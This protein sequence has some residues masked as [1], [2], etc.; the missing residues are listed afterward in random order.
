MARIARA[1]A[2][3]LVGWAAQFGA[4][5]QSGANPGDASQRAEERVRAVYESRAASLDRLWARVVFEL[6]FR[7]AEGVARSEQGEG[8]LQFREPGRLALTLGK[9]GQRVLYLGCDPDRFWFIDMTDGGRAHVGRNANVGKPCMEE[10][11]LPA[12][13]AD[14][15][16]MLGVSRLPEGA[17]GRVGGGAGEARILATTPT[18]RLRITAAVETGEPSRIELLPSAADEGS[19]WV[20]VPT[21]VAS[22]SEYTSVDL[23]AGGAPARVPHKI[24]ME[25]RASEMTLTLWIFDP[26]RGTERQLP[27]EAFDVEFLI[28]TLA[29]A[30][31]RRLDAPCDDVRLPETPESGSPADRTP[32]PG[33]AESTPR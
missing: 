18:G 28:E 31:L 5:A 1:L 20:G 30:R 19:A 11:G 15:L 25:A 33:P 14:V 22:L 26:V 7:D 9:V 32:A 27:P 23:R 29:P 13:P 17:V 4:L 24:V 12:N 6:K 16:W 2:I 21:I 3:G 8:H 10:T